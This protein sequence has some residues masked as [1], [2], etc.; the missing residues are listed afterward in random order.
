MKTQRKIK[1]E[2]A[3]KEAAFELI[4]QMAQ[5]ESNNMEMVFVVEGEKIRFSAALR[6]VEDPEDEQKSS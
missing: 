1:D 3:M 6:Y 4:R 2:K 5:S